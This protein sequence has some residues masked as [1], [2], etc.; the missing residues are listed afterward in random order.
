MADNELYLIDA[1]GFCYRAFYAISGLATSFGQ[2]TNAVYG[3]TNILNKLLKDKQPRYIAACFDVSRDTF[4]AKK[5]A[6][7]K[8]QRPAMANELSCQIPWIKELISADGVAI[9]EKSGFEAD[10]II[11]TAAK[12]AKDRGFSVV[13]V[14]SDKDMLQLVDEN[15]AVFNPYKE[16]GRIYDI[17]KVKDN[18]GVLPGQMP[19]LIALMGDQTDNI[20]G[21]RGIGEKTAI[22]LIGFWGDI[23]RLLSN[24]ADIKPERI[25]KTIGDNIENIKLSR[26]LAVLDVN[27]DIDLDLDKL[28][29]KPADTMALSR[30]FKRL[31]FK[32]FLRE[33]PAHQQSDTQ[34]ETAVLN[35]VDLPFP[36]EIKE[37]SLYGGS[38]EDMVFY[39]GKGLFR[40]SDLGENIRKILAD[41]SIKKT[42]QD[43]KKT[44]ISLVQQ[45]IVLAGFGFDIKI[46]GH[47]LNPASSAENLQDI[48]SEHLEDFGF[49]KSVDNRRALE[50]ILK[51]K[52]IL[53]NKLKQSSLMELFC[54]IE[55]PLAEVLSD[56]ESNGIRVDMDILKVLSRDLETQLVDLIG[57]IY[58][59]SGA[60]FNINSPK[61]LR[62]VL[63]EKLK[64]PVVKR[65]KT[66]PSTDEEVLQKLGASHKLPAL[67][68]EYRHLTKLKSVYVDA[69]M[70]LVDIKTGRVHT[71]FN[72]TATQ[73]GR[74]SSSE[75]NL[76]NLPVKTEI[77]G[78]IRQAIIAS[79]GCYLLACDY[80]QV[81][82]R[83]LA[84]IS[85]DENLISAFR[86]DKDI[87]RMTAGL[88]F[89]LD[90]K[91][92]DETMR[93]T[94]KRI[95]F[96]IIYGISAY[97]LSKDLNIPVEEAGAFIDAYF[98]RYPRV[99]DYI[100]Q[101]IKKAERD[102]FVATISGRRR[103]IPEIN[104]KNQM[105][106]QFS[107]RQAVNTP[108]QGSASDLI[109]LAMIEINGLIRREKYGSKMLL[110]VHDELIFDVP[111]DELE[112]FGGLVKDKMENVLKLD[113]PIKVNVKKGRNWLEVIPI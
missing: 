53:E 63:F 83:I 7:Y 34:E 102:G 67:L 68:L 43:L 69:L 42:G 80:S 112:V 106:R 26:E 56:M 13:I 107:Q 36:A 104:S 22:E 2:P 10:D 23:Q 17:K 1:T 51:L 39:A 74:L 31:E 11:A 79:D 101:Q 71:N 55:M 60:E 27:V 84:H 105:V 9:L 98:A 38:K 28:K 66:G 44:K 18:F 3:F 90:E 21:A 99:K 16:N 20:P 14:S 58:R 100:E 76:Q 19:D 4:R 96:G 37:L 93:E 45:G 33:L 15:T 25:K 41:P 32:K 5:F 86:G 12:K 35:D 62:G 75:P 108:I 40:L 87:H 85:G 59:I 52:P 95:N 47:L 70:H 24:I 103:Y 61:Q 111:Q 29:I 57:N 49:A 50:L 94:A 77:G 46:A 109:K 91:D 78:K 73:T 54:G 88:I 72:Q 97:G 89:G 110:Q 113:V 30:L 6:Q 81:E 48:A 8:I 82:L 65:S 64:L 92:V